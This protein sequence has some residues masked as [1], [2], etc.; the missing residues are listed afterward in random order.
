MKPNIGDL[1]HFRKVCAACNKMGRQHFTFVVDDPELLPILPEF[2]KRLYSYDA[3][4][5][6]NIW[7]D[8]SPSLLELYKTKLDGL[9]QTLSALVGRRET[10]GY[11]DT[12][13]IVLGPDD[14]FLMGPSRDIVPLPADE[15]QNSLVT[16]VASRMNIKH[17]NYID[18]RIRHPE[19]QSELATSLA[20]E[21]RTQLDFITKKLDAVQDILVEKIAESRRELGLSQLIDNSALASAALSTHETLLTAKTPIDSPQFERQ[22]QIDFQKSAQS[23]GYLGSESGVL[24]T[25]GFWPLDA[26][27]N[28]IAQ[29]ILNVSLQTAVQD[30]WEDWTVGFSK[31]FI[32]ARPKEF[33]L[34]LVIGLGFADGNAL[35][36][37]YIN[38]ERVKLG[39]QPLEV[40]YPLRSLVRSY[41]PLKSEP[42][43]AQ[44]SDD[45][46]RSG[47]AEGG[48]R[49]RH[50]YSGVYVPR[51]KDFPELSIHKIARLIADGLLRLRG[52]KLLRS[53]WQDIGI[54]VNTGPIL[55]PEEWEEGP[56]VPSMTAAYV[57]AWRLPP[58]MEQPAHFPPPNS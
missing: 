38:C 49:V 24:Y 56:R 14:V 48:D 33:L 10:H 28:E 47:Y 9:L 3:G 20:A 21:Y 26:D 54:A 29:D 31:S 6:L 35:V 25:I 50:D 40:S 18:L 8:H 45:M 58:G 13:L 57:I 34:C 53:D 19:K 55:P 1:I 46:S 43:I 15:V 37:N 36:T 27:E 12:R 32:P 11:E 16:Q 23:V 44:F 2:S 7:F 17:F 39:V 22:V 51:P 52:D 5:R 41:L 30:Y 42:D 4:R